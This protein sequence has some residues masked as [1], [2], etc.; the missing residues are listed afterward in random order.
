MPKNHRG[1]HLT[2]QAPPTFRCD[3]CCRPFP[4][5]E[6]AHVDRGVK[7]CPNCLMN[8]LKHI[9]SLAQESE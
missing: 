1:T 5:S 9:R 2:T 6:I 3:G 8:G 7:I 4:L